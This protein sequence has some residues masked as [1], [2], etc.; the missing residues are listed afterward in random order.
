M[1]TG[2]QLA[3]SS[4]LALSLCVGVD[5]YELSEKDTSLIMNK[6]E[7]NYVYA[8]PTKT[9]ALPISLNLAY[10]FP[11][12]S[13]LQ[14]YLKAGGGLCFGRYIDREANRKEK[15]IKFVYPI[16]QNAK[17]VGPFFVLSSGLRWQPAA[18]TGFFLEISYRHAKLNDF[19]GENKAGLRGPLEY[20][21]EYLPHLDFW[22]TKVSI[23]TTELDPAITRMRQPAAVDFSSFS[24]KMG[25]MVRF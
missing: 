1:E 24:V 25:L 17:A 18:F 7:E 3:L 12:S 23:V 16:Y 13:R 6:G 22:R 14:L 10:Y 15:E 8:R 5:H 19:E 2:I 20:Y 11:L 4:R 9:S 21:E